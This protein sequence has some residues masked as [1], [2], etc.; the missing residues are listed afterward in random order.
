DTEWYALRAG[1]T[2]DGPEDREELVRHYLRTPLDRRVSPQPLFDP[3]WFAARTKIDLSGKDPFLTY[4]R[5]RAWG[6]ATHPLFSTV[7][8][9]RTTPGAMEHPH[10]PIGHYLEVG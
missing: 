4:L 6:T 3:E 1:L 8:Y 2:S 5:R 9:R 10:G 7:H